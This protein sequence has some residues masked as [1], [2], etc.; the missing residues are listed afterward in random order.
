VPTPDR[1]L[2]ARLDILVG[3]V[4]ERHGLALLSDGRLAAAEA[5]IAAGPPGSPPPEG[6][7][8]QPPA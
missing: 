7:A 8:A 5:R 4:A 2:L 3:L 1:G 6:P